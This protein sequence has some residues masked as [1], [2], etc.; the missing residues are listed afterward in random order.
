[1]NKIDSIT[2]LPIGFS[3]H[4]VKLLGSI[5]K[6]TKRRP[7]SYKITSDLLNGAE[8][9]IV[10]GDDRNALEVWRKLYAATGGKPSLLVSQNSVQE[11]G[12]VH[13]SRPLIFT[14]V[15]SALDRAAIDD[16]KIAPDLVIAQETELSNELKDTLERVPATDAR[17]R[18]HRALVVDD[19]PS[20]RKLMEIELRI[21]G[22]AG[23][24]AES[25]EAAWRLLSKE[26][27]NIV[28]L[29]V[30]LPDIDGYHICKTIRRN[31]SMKHTPVIML[32]GRSS[33]FD[34]VRGKLAGCSAYLV[35]PVPHEALQGVLSR[36][37]PGEP[38]SFDQLPIT[39][40]IRG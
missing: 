30:E 15:V 35:K 14:R 16:L 17:R 37:L 25:A 4:D 28:F 33:T 27:Y 24:Y 3:D 20:I 1:M 10:N 32:T 8:I 34:K 2:V 13:V 18:H 39:A 6:L 22:V 26:T 36:Y 5:A 19:S 21:S 11:A 40:I 38:L 29:D 31:I 23:D 12:A 7:R 9:L